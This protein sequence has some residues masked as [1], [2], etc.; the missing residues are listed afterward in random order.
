MQKTFLFAV[1][2]DFSVGDFGLVSDIQ[3]GAVAVS[4][5]GGYAVISD[6]YVMA[7]TA[8]LTSELEQEFHDQ[9]LY[10]LRSVEQDF[11]L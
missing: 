3:V 1:V 4:S 6:E 10:Y 7:V 2:V 5:I 8:C 11:L 9:R